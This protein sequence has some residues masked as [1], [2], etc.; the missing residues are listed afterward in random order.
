MAVYTP[1]GTGAQDGYTVVG[2]PNTWKEDGVTLSGGIS[3]PIGLRFQL[4]TEFDS[5][6]RPIEPALVYPSFDLTLYTAELYTIGTAFPF[7]LSVVVASAPALYSDSLL[8]NLRDET[9]LYD[10]S[11]D[12]ATQSLVLNDPAGTAL[13][14]SS[15]STAPLVQYL[16]HSSYNGYI[17]LTITQTGLGGLLF[18]SSE[19]TNSALRPTLT[20][21]EESF[22]TGMRDGDSIGRRSRMRHCP[23]TGMP[24]AS[25]DM[26]RDGWSEGLMVSPEGFDP[27]DPRDKYVPNP[28]EGVVDDEV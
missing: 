3:S 27:E 15:V 8:P 2:V 19:A 14:F 17:C 18:H 20:T 11:G 26:I 16:R 4:H 21:T 22:T 9:A 1:L 13:T 6:S 7:S 23:R 10:T 24:V 25:D 5:E 12:L 28:N